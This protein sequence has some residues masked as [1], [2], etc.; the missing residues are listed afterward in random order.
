[1]LKSSQR[2]VGVVLEKCSKHMSEDGVISLTAGISFCLCTAVGRQRGGG[3]IRINPTV[4]PLGPR[5]TALM[6]KDNSTT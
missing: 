6:D 2:V 1:M 3:K 5:G 4:F